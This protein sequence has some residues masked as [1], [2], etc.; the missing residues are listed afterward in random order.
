MPS[1]SCTPSRA[2]SQP[3]S[4]ARW[5]NRNANA[6]VTALSPRWRYSNGSAGSTCAKC[7]TWPPSC[8]SA[9]K[10]SRPPIG[11][12]T[13]RTSPGTCTA[14]QKAR[15]DFPGRRS[16]SSCTFGCAAGSIPSPASV[17]SKLGSS[18][19][20][21]NAASA[22]AKRNRRGRSER[23][24]ASSP[25]PSSVRSTT[26]PTSGAYA[27][28]VAAVK[29]AVARERRSRSKPLSCSHSAR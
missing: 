23:A 3:G 9:T 15:G 6:S 22:S 17:A 1:A 26:G 24:S 21:S 7:S 14:T 5:S 25:T 19:A 10:S 29:A 16:T 18:C 2:R 11:G 27:S 13:S 4:S 12:T 20:P 8:S 28:S